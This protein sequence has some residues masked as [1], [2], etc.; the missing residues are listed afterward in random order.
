MFWQ[1]CFIWIRKIK[2]NAFYIIKISFSQ[3][4][5]STT[6]KFGKIELHFKYYSRELGFFFLGFAVASFKKKKKSCNE[7]LTAKITDCLLYPNTF[8]PLFQ[9]INSSD[10]D[11][12]LITPV[13][14]FGGFVSM[15][16]CS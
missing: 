5:K 7:C 13:M 14:G 3:I 10:N 9:N 15:S 8:G 6:M 4:L 11:S 2:E 12:T 1:L 16:H